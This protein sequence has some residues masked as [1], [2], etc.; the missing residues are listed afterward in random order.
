MSKH[1]PKTLQT[2]KSSEYFPTP[3]REAS[4]CGE[5]HHGRRLLSALETAE[6]RNSSS[7]SASIYSTQPHTIAVPGTEFPASLNGRILCPH[8]NFIFHTWLE[9][10][11]RLHKSSV[12]SG[13]EENHPPPLRPHHNGG[14]ALLKG[15][16]YKDFFLLW[17][18]C[19][20]SRQA[21]RRE[22]GLYNSHIGAPAN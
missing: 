22:Q 7:G 16:G 2:A 21:E 14:F 12:S 15:R 20:T 11:K 9:C 8:P 13:A 19:N 10:E 6:S 3:E 4:A 1:Q 17:T 5:E 18:P